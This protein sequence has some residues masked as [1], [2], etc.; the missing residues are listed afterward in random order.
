MWEDFRQQLAR[1]TLV[2]VVPYLFAS[3]SEPMHLSQLQHTVI[4]A[5][6]SMAQERGMIYGSW[7]EEE[8][9]LGVTPET[10][11]DCKSQRLE[12]MA[13]AGTSHPSLPIEVFKKDPKEL[14]EHALVVEGI[15]Q[16][17]SP[18]GKLTIGPLE[19]LQLT[20]LHHLRTL[21]QLDMDQ[22]TSFETLVR[23]LHPT[24]ALGAFPREQGAL[25]LQ[26]HQQQLD[27]GRYGAPAGA[28]W[29]SANIHKCLVAIRNV[30][31]DQNGKRIGAG[32]GIVEESQKDKELK[33]IQLKIQAIRHLLKI[34]T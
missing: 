13:L 8:G 24:P 23:T 18:L 9:V 11:F 15:K 5:L 10:L 12:T 33:E 14:R 28:I 19:V 34:G 17:L 26:R 22:S 16:A 6:E 29:A 3:Q 25:W 7:N 21:I 20:H 27:R 30:Q 32:C 1:G 4:Q 2:K 31:W